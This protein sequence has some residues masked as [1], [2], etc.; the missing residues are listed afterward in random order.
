MSIQD[1]FATLGL[2]RRYDIDLPQ[3]EAHY[4]ELQRALHPDRHV[5]AGPAQRRVSLAKA[6]EV[7]EAYRALKDELARGEALLALAR[8]VAGGGERANEAPD[9]LMEMMELR[10]ELGEARAAR[11]LARVQRLAADVA[12][13]H[14]Q[15]RAA[16]SRAFDAAQA[17]E[18]EREREAQLG[19]A[20]RLLG[21]LKYYRRFLDEVS[22][23]EEE[24]LG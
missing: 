8:G 16:L 7:N 11:D 18:L 19:Q 6:V 13:H 22:A 5:S 15:T 17:V 10:E 23:I 3:L 12:A 9:F 21:R 4:R 2:P 14:D 20:A 1:P 24:S